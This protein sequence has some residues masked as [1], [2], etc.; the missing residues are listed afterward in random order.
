MSGVIAAPLVLGL[1]L[2]VS[3]LTWWMLDQPWTGRTHFLAIAAAATRTVDS[4]RIA[5]LAALEQPAHGV[6]HRLGERAGPVAEDLHYS[7][8]MEYCTRAH[9]AGFRLRRIPDSVEEFTGFCKKNDL[10]GG[11]YL[12]YGPANQSAASGA[13]ASTAARISSSRPCMDA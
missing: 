5:V 7:M 9:F 13:A 1:T 10:L 8:D 11:D 6:P 2:A 3:L 12:G 4:L